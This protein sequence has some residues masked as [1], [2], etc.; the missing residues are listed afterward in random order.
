MKGFDITFNGIKKT[1]SAE[2]DFLLFHIDKLSSNENAIIRVYGIDYEMYI[3]KY[4]F[5]DVPIKL[6]DVI[7]IKMCEI[8]DETSPEREVFDRNIQRL[9]PKV[10]LRA[11]YELENYL[12][13]KELL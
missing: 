11:F 12:K 2:Y 13:E 7:N 1:I 5:Y 9:D 10:K 8:D 3:R 4:W 6:N